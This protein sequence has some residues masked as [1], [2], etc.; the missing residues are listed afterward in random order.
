MASSVNGCSKWNH[1]Q[2]RQ[3]IGATSSNTPGQENQETKY[4]KVTFGKEKLGKA[5]QQKVK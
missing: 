3:A 1:S 5:R 4:I 2:E